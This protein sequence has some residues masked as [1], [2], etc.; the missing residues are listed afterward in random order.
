MC[1]QC[2]YRQLSSS[3]R[4]LRPDSNSNKITRANCGIENRKLGGEQANQKTENSCRIYVGS[5]PH[6]TI[7]N[8]RH[9]TPQQTTTTIANYHQHYQSLPPLPTTTTTDH[10][11]LPLPSPGTTTKPTK[12]AHQAKPPKPQPR[13]RSLLVAL[14]P[15]CVRYWRH[16]ATFSSN[17]ATRP[18]SSPATASQP[19]SDTGNR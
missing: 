7:I 19:A 8:T 10:S 2:V 12:P 14:V 11:Q 9:T 16:W 18:A 1:L 17:T 3:T 6:N 15:W 13:A 4:I 5:P